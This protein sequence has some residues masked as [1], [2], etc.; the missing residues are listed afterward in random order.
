[1]HLVRDQGIEGSNPSF[2]T[3]KRNQNVSLA[4]NDQLCAVIR[5]YGM[6]RLLNAIWD[7]LKECAK[8]TV[9]VNSHYPW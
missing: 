3:S 6:S 1:M 9:E 7:F 5:R 8:L 2:R 4:P